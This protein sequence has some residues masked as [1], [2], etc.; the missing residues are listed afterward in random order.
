MEESVVW[1]KRTTQATKTIPLSACESFYVQHHANLV[2]A[3]RPRVGFFRFTELV[4]CLSF[5]W[6]CAV[7]SMAVLPFLFAGTKHWSL[8][9]STWAASWGTWLGESCWRVGA[10]PSS[11]RSTGTTWWSC[12]SSSRASTSSTLWVSS[13]SLTTSWAP[14]TT[15]MELRCCKGRSCSFPGTEGTAKSQN[16]GV[17][18]LLGCFWREKSINVLYQWAA[19]HDLKLSSIACQCWSTMFLCAHWDQT[20]RKRNKT[21]I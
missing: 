14:S 16:V 1:Q 7:Y 3:E 2:F 17:F 5:S 11:T 10:S 19:V 20:H 8:W 12:C 6:N 15:C 9:R 18:R 4:Q 21:C 13:T